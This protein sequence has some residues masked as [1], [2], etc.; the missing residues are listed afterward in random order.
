MSE[1]ELQIALARRLEA[2]GHSVALHDAGTATWEKRFSTNGIAPD[3]LVATS[4]KWEYHEVMPFIQIETKIG[5]AWRIAEAADGLDKVIE[6]RK[7]QERLSYKFCGKQI[8]GPFFALLTNP[9]LLKWDSVS[10]W[11]TSSPE[12]HPKDP[13][14]CSNYLTN[15]MIYLLNRY[16]G[17]LLLSDFSFRFEGHF[18]GRQFSRR[19]FLSPHR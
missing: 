2:F 9:C 3:L 18:G 8:A 6:L 16:Q 19:F 4:P 10:F 15:F 14:C 12:F 1:A 11:R 17:S 13:R 5:H 7:R